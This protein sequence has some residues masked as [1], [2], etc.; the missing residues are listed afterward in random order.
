MRAF[1]KVIPSHSMFYKTLL[2]MSDTFSSFCSTPPQTTPDSLLLTGIRRTPCATL[3][4][5]ML[6]G[7]LSESSPHTKSDSETSPPSSVWSARRRPPRI[8][9]FKLGNGS[10][11]YFVYWEPVWRPRHL[12]SK[13]RDFVWCSF[14]RLFMCG[15]LS[16]PVLAVW[17]CS[18][19]FAGQC[20][21]RL[22]FRLSHQFPFSL[23]P[24]PSRL[25][26]PQS[27]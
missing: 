26:S 2:D 12:P 4:G 16:L 11:N 13:S 22:L 15:T 9:S 7:H 23:E 21:S 20:N 27:C 24:S 25:C 6:Y 3:P 5:G 1:L 18:V 8:S 10:D 14:G 17:L 19:L